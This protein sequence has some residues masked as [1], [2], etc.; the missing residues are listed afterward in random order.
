MFLILV[1]KSS[2]MR[3]FSTGRRATGMQAG[4]MIAMMKAVQSKAVL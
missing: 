2:P 4:G 1:G 3:M